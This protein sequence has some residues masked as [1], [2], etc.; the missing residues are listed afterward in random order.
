MFQIRAD[1]DEQLE[2]KTNLERAHEF[3]NDV[4]NFVE[5]MPGVERIT[6]EANGVMRWLIR[7]D[8]PLIGAI[9][10]VFTVEQTDDRPERIEWS[11]AG[12]ERKN[13]LRYAASFEQRG[14]RVLVR[15]AQRV[16][17]RRQ[18]ARELHALAGWVGATRLSAEMQKGI[19]EMMRVFLGRAREKLEQS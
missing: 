18:H 14:A 9:R 3:F 2:I 16:E 11:P 19:S 15:I 10:Q 17:I 1:F 13:L 4:R 8:V 6:A 12:E 5:L 7:A